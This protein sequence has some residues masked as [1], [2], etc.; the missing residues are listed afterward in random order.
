MTTL[1]NYLPLPY[2]PP[3]PTQPDTI[4]YP[5]NACEINQPTVLRTELAFEN[6]NYCNLKRKQE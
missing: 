3:P 2:P 1:A 6:E 4:E 5:K